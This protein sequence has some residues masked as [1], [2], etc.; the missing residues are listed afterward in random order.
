MMSR[1]YHLPPIERTWEGPIV[2]IWSNYPGCSV[3][4]VLTKEWEATT[5]L[6]WRQGAQKRLLLNLSKGNPR[7]SPSP[8]SWHNRL[9]LWWPNLLCHFQSSKEDYEIKHLKEDWA[10]EK[11]AWKK[12]PMWEMP[13]TRLPEESRT[14]ESDLWKSTLKSASISWETESRLYLNLSTRATSFKVN[15]SFTLMMPVPSTLAFL[16]SLKV[17]YSLSDRGVRLE[18]YFLFLVMCHEQPESMSHV[19]SKLPSITYIGWE[20]VDDLV[21]GLVR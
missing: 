11:L 18:N 16:S 12:F 10:D 9:K 15:Q 7:S 17:T 20:K 21:M 19:S 8:L 3:I 6:S 4:M 5:I 13:Q 14:C 1:T 2:S